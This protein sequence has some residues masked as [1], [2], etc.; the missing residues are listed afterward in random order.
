M[1]KNNIFYILITNIIL[2][3]SVIFCNIELEELSSFYDYSAKDINGKLISMD[4]FK[5]KSILIV[6]VASRCGYTSQYEGLQELYETY[7]DSLV[8]LGFPSND[9][10]WQ[11]PGTNSDIKL[12]CQRT[13]GVNFPMFEKIHVKGKNKHPIYEWLSAS[14]MNGWNNETPDWNFNKYLLNKEGELIKVFKADVKPQD[15]LITNHFI[16]KSSNK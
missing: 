12:F 3:L 9:F 6:N 14:K 5:G 8:V 1:I 15:T 10:L 2:Y 16:I 4:S 11:E 7:N 13:Y